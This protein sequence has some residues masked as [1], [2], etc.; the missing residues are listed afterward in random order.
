MTLVPPGGALR[1][2]CTSILCGGGEGWSAKVIES[3]EILPSRFMRSQEAAQPNLRG[4][5]TLATLLLIP[6]QE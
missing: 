3:L 5:G 2:T 1:A 6:V 4:H